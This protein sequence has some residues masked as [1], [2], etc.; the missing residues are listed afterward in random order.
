MIKYL[1]TFQK[2]SLLP[3]DSHKGKALVDVVQISRPIKR[4]FFLDYI[5]STT[6]LWH[7]WDALRV[8]GI[9]FHN[10]VQDGWNLEGTVSDAN[11]FNIYNSNVL[12]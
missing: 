4:F 5:N 11:M 8:L 10:Q 9:L 2:K 12:C 3:Y 6:L 7:R 1:I